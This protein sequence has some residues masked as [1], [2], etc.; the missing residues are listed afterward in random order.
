MCHDT[1]N[2]YSATDAIK[3]L[4]I[5]K[6]LTK[7]ATINSTPVQILTHFIFEALL[8]YSLNQLG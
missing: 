6:L 5:V 2:I 7:H 3:I 1:F 4:N 8:K